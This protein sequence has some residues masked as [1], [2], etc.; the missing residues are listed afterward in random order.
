MNF[1]KIKFKESSNSRLLRKFLNLNFAEF[2]QLKFDFLNGDG[3][4]A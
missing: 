4:I 2:M 3:Y 1:S